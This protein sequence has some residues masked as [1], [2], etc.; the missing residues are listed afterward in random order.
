MRLISVLLLFAA[1][2]TAQHAVTIPSTRPRRLARSNRSTPIS[3]TNE[4]NYT[5]MQNG[6]KLVGELAAM[7]EAPVYIRTH[8]MLTRAD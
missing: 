8:F 2:A 7:S 3:V 4:L 6:R 5:Y 1:C